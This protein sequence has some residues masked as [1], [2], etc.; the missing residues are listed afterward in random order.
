M[1]VFMEELTRELER[2]GVAYKCQESGN[3]ARK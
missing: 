2:R 1:G 3:E